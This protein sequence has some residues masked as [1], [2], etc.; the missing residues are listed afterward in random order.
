MGVKSEKMEQPKPCYLSNFILDAYNTIAR[1]RRYEN[2]IPLTLSMRD[3][4]DYLSMIELPCSED[5]F[6]E[7]VFMLDNIFI[8]EAHKKIK[9]PAK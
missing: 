2:G 3:I 8:D 5:A 4:L 1:S 9:K 7:S 6:T